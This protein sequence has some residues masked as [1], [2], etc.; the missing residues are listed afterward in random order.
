MMW[1]Q[2]AENNESGDGKDEFVGGYDKKNQFG[3]YYRFRDPFK[4][5]KETF[6]LYFEER[7]WFLA[8]LQFDK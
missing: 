6:K 4:K 7:L 8:K 1:H 3:D 5:Y 2:I